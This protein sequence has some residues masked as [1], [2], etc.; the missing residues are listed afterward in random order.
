MRRFL[1]LL[2]FLILLSTQQLHADWPCSPNLSVALAVASNNQWNVRLAGDGKAGVYAVWQDRRGGVTDKLYI[3][4]VDGTGNISWRA[5]GIPISGSGGFQYYP[6]I[7][8][9]GGGD[10]IV[11]W[12]DNRSNVDYD[13][14]AQRISSN[15][16]QYWAPGGVVICNAS[17]NQ[18]NPQLVSDGTGGEII[19]WQD[20]RNGNADIYV[21]RVNGIGQAVWTSNGVA[22]CTSTNQQINPRLVGDGQGGAF[23]TWTDY[24]DGSGMS[25]IYCQHVLANGQVALAANGIPVCTA[26]NT[27]W[28]PQIVSD[29]ALGAIIC[30]QDR[31][32][33]GADQ[34]FAQRIDR[35]GAPAWAANGIP[36]ASST[37]IQYDPCLASDN[38]GG[39]VAVWQDNRTGV[40]YDIYAQRVN[41]AGQ[42]L[43]ASD[44]QPLCVA[45]GQQYNPQLVVDGQSVL[46]TWQDE[47]NG[48]DYD[49]FAQRVILSGVPQW[50]P[51]G[52]PI[53][54]YP[55][56]QVTP[57]IVGDGLQGAIIAW[58][59]Y[60]DGTGTTD[61]YAQRVS[62]SGKLA[63]GC[64]RSF[65]QDSLALKSIRLYV[66]KKTP[67]RMPNA[68]NVR[69]SVFSHGAFPSGI[70]VG[71]PRPDSAKFYGGEIFNKGI[72]IKNGLPDTG[73]ARPFDRIY[74]R[75][76]VG[77][78]RNTNAHSYNNRLLGELLALRI[79][80]AASDVRITDSQFGDLIFNDPANPANLLNHKSL[81]QVAAYVD[82][83]LTLWKWY[84]GI[85]YLQIAASI[86]QVNNAFDGL[87]D[88]TST[89]PLKIKSTKAL[90]S[91]PFFLPNPQPLTVLPT[92]IP[93][94]VDE[95]VTPQNYVLYQ[96]YPNPFNP[97]T[98]IAFDL[99]QPSVVTLKV[100]NLLGQEMTTLL[101]HVA[102]DEG[103]QRVFF[104]A[105]AAGGMASGVYFYRLI[106]EDAGGSGK[107]TS[108]VKKML[109][110]K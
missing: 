65:T 34:I 63:G 76:F 99:P 32:S 38:A 53:V 39:A 19:A 13:I 52:I 3:Q 9:D 26:P 94:A 51:D 23:M 18:Y 97:T 96:N 95:E 16:N 14:Y 30:W 102:M 1:L 64:Y 49:I 66:N 28:N 56:N 71:I 86:R 109:M 81:R 2:L 5:G 10:V 12:Q 54:S 50:A 83:L 69:D 37:G 82:S 6:Q 62:T 46:V 93:Q 108:A 55:A 22:V 44:G 84:S 100:Y 70:T 110:I 45:A 74:G 25:D 7:L 104:D 75:K 78:T 11:V 4:H 48:T 106:T 15:G 35:T 87:V 85:N 59:D 31:R 80:I 17:G 21:Q 90:F 91:V 88:S 24:R 8:T 33:G 60:R 98:T 41:A 61:L 105:S 67:V 92:F 77:L 79:N 103:N 29:D 20:Y 72:N 107:M 68:G 42:L 58:S 27:Q 36:L 47:R 101:D 57:Q 40:D 89:R 73:I 43:W